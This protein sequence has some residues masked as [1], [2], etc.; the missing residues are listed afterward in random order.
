MTINEM[1][2]LI[3]LSCIDAVEFI[4]EEFW[5]DTATLFID[6]PY[7]EKGKDL[8]N[9]YYNERDHIKLAVV[10][11]GLHVGTPNA[12]IVVTYDYNKW[13]QDTFT[14]HDDELVIGRNYSI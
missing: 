7:L 10:L 3:E 5:D 4:E 14:G 12:D 2:D 13:L 6:P 9:C 1:A 8:Y 11:E